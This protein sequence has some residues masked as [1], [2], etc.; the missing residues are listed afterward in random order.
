MVDRY[1]YYL[2]Y[3][4]WTHP[5]DDRF[6]FSFRSSFVGAERALEPTFLGNPSHNLP[7]KGTLSHHARGFL[8][9]LLIS[10]SRVG[11]IDQ[12]FWWYS[13]PAHV[14]AMI[15]YHCPLGQPGTFVDPRARNFQDGSVKSVVVDKD[16]GPRAGETRVGVEFGMGPGAF[17]LVGVGGLLVYALVIIGC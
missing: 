7:S 16:E 17:W 14:G 11:S 2:R 13:Q 12:P 5:E 3:H 15:W 1:N 10:S 6:S 9:G 4:W 8:V